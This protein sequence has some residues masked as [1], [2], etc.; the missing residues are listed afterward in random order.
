MNNLSIPELTSHILRV[1]YKN[2]I[3]IN[4]LQLNLILY[5]FACRVR[6]DNIEITYTE[7]SYFY[8]SQYGINNK[9]V[10]YKYKYYCTGIILLE[11][12]DIYLDSLQNY[13]EFL[14]SIIK[15]VKE[16]MFYLLDRLRENDINYTKRKL[17]EKI[18]I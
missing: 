3:G 9:Y 13:E 2:N 17:N 10:I 14:L 11:D 5:F 7:N 6:E 18:Y 8:K 16:D 15:L 4:Y 12:S 1:T